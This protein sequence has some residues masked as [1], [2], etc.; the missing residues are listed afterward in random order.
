MFA[1]TVTFTVRAGQVDFFLPLVHQNART[2]MTKEPG[3]IQFDV[4]YDKARPNM[5]FL[6]EVYD[7][8]AAFQ[9]HLASAHYA[10]F[11]K[12]VVDMVSH[13]DIH[14]YARVLR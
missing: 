13:K 7:N 4:C 5:V 10:E 8:E 9:A 14:S 1:I 11:Q 3:C 2:S 12:A 6:Y